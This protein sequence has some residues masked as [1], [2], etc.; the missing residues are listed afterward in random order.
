[1]KVKSQYTPCGSKTKPASC[2][3]V[4]RNVHFNITGGG[5]MATLIGKSF[6]NPPVK[7]SIFPPPDVG[8]RP[9]G[10]GSTVNRRSTSAGRDLV[11]MVPLAE[12]RSTG[13]VVSALLHTADGS[14]RTVSS[15][16]LPPSL[17]L[18]FPPK[19]NQKRHI[20]IHVFKG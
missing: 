6:W 9:D 7:L 18:S 15:L 14:A 4:N 3:L 1:M 11:T 17:P 2:R 16:S 20:C 19:L 5:G 8:A 12:T 13:S 10:R